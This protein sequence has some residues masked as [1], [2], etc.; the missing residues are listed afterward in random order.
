MSGNTFAFQKK[1]EQ[2]MVGPD[3]VVTHPLSFF[4]RDFYHSLDAGR[5]NDL[6]NDDSLITADHGLDRLTNL[7]DINPE[8]PQHLMG[9]AF[10][11]AHKAEEQ[12]L[13]ADVAVAGRVRL[14]PGKR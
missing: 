9:N 14:L 12:M 5:W 3:G 6:L 2:Q 13:S 10:A 7:A 11:F 8:V 1:A 4:E